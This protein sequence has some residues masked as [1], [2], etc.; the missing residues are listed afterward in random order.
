MKPDYL[1][2]GSGLAGLSFGALMA[3]SG[4]RVRIIEAHYLPGGYGHTFDM[5]NYKFNA[6]L[7]Y[8]WNCGEG[9][10]VHTVL[11]ELG[12]T[13]TVTFQEYDPLGFDRMRMPG[14]ALDIPNDYDLLVQRL[15]TLFPEY[16]VSLAR[17]VYA[18]RDMSAAIDNLPGITLNDLAS[19]QTIKTAFRTASQIPTLLRYQRSTLQDVF[20]DFDL[21]VA[22]QTLLGL[23][24]P[25]FMLPPNQLSFMAWLLLFTGYMRGAYYPSQH[26]EAV[27]NGFVS[28]I[29]Q[30]GGEI[31]YEQKAIAFE[32]E[33]NTIT[34]VVSEDLRHR[35][36]VHEHEAATIICNM[37]PRQA[38]EMIGFTHFG[39]KIKLQIK[40]RIF[41]LQFY[42]LC[43]CQRY[44]L[45]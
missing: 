12:L 35:G 7:H 13:E 39:P 27:I 45:T 3:K 33:G 38:A 32:R 30:N 25:D 14:Y 18:V 2:V 1:I 21:P 19:V 23:Q 26:F 15:Q 29:E 5:G 16:R 4:K 10:T 9:R 31:C 17:F 11:K 40:L 24:W 22:A 34:K 20:D 37:D 36:R 43:R 8:V 6:Q 42:G 44:R 28:V 41:L